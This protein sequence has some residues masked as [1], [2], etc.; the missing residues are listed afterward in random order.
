[1]LDYSGECNV[2][3]RVLV[4]GKQEGHSKGRCK[5]WRQRSETREDAMLR[6]LK[7]EKAAM[8][9]GTGVASRRGERQE[10]GFFPR[11]SRGN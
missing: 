2:I 7:M 1:M 5:E 8:S 9:R 6:M 3:T 11:V 10:S 4:S